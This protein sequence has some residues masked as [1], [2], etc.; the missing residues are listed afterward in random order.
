MAVPAPVRVTYV[1][2]YAEVEIPRAGRTCRRGESVEVAAD[3]AGALLAQPDN[4][5]PAS[6]VPASPAKEEEETHAGS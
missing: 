1:G 3:M 4:W 6:S 2:P 5:Q